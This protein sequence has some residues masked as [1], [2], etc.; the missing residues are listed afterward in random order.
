MSA[1]IGLSC[2][3]DIE[4]VKMDQEMWLEDFVAAAWIGTQP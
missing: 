1:D 2:I 3:E 4:A